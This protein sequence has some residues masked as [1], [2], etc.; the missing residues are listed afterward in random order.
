MMEQTTN[1]AIPESLAVVFPW[2]T[3]KIINNYSLKVN[4][5]PYHDSWII[6]TKQITKMKRIIVKL[7]NCQTGKSYLPNTRHLAGFPLTN[8]LAMSLSDNS[9]VICR[10]TWQTATLF[11]RSWVVFALN[12][13]FSLRRA[14][15][16]RSASQ[17]LVG[18]TRAN[19][20]SIFTW[21]NILITSGD[22]SLKTCMCSAMVVLL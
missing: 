18:D 6:K 19:F 16:E 4:F 12:Q 15:K 21:G 10:C 9:N 14:L 8:S 7:V 20:N 11:K 2:T 13:V 5:L 3:V 1:S 22:I 17:E